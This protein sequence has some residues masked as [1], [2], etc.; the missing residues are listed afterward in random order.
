M[1][2]YQHHPFSCF[3]IANH[4]VAQQTFSCPDVEESHACFVGIVSDGVSDVVVQVVHQMALFHWQ[5]FVEGTGDMES[6]GIHL[7]EIHTRGY[8]LLCKP[9]FVGTS[10]FQ[11]V[12]VGRGLHRTQD[13]VEFRQFHLADAFQLVVNLLLLHFQ[14][15]AVGHILPFATTTYSK[16]SAHRFHPH[17]TVFD[18]PH[19]LCLAVA[20][21]LPFHLQIDHVARH[22]ERYEYHHVVD[23]CN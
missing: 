9:P 18:K 5:Y 8:L 20:V 19:N 12:A 2:L 1:E 6:Y 22:T 3:R 17:V 7:R 23:P 14:L 16:V 11:L 10:K 21:L 4:D 13:G 15:F